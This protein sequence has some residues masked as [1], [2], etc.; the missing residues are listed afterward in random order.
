VNE[1]DFATR[2][3]EL[4]TRIGYPMPSVEWTDHRGPYMRID[5]R[6]VAGPV[7]RL[8]PEVAQWCSSLRD[9]TIAQM[10]L[11]AR[12]GMSRH[13]RQLKIWGFGL[14]A[15][16]AFVLG[17]RFGPWVYVW[18]LVAWVLFTAASAIYARRLFRKV[19]PELVGMFGPDV[20]LEALEHLR[21][22]LTPARFLGW[23]W[24]GAG[25]LPAERIKW[26]RAVAP[27]NSFV[28]D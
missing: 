17:V 28:A 26:V 5:E 7:L 10:M 20:V 8:R 3:G 21:C 6:R 14:T 2:V 4:A 19:D 13:H 1:Q 23:L 12:F 18:P 27:G 24:G 15:A 16:V 11:C 25:V 9:V 22:P